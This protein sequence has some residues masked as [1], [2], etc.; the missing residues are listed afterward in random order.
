MYRT[1]MDDLCIWK[2]KNNRKPLILQGARQ[3]GKTWIMQEFGR[4]YF[5]NVAY[6][7]MDN[8]SRM[9][10]C[11]AKD[12]NVDR[13]IEELSVES[14]EQIIP[15]QTLIILDEVQEV[16]IALTAL[17]YFCED[18]P[19]QH[20]M[21][22][23]SLL[24]VAIHKGI[25]YPVGKVDILKMYPMTFDE[26]LRALQE[27]QLAEYS[28][29]LESEV[30][31]TFKDKYIDY[32]KKYYYIG[33]MPEAVLEYKNNKDYKEVRNIQKNIL[34]MYENDFGKHIDNKTELE[35]TRMVWNSI[36]M[37][38]SKENKKF[39]FRENK[40]GWKIERV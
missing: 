4:M 13:I 8:N 26:F 33:G 31:V 3:V 34:E 29:N 36:P 38:L 40:K 35:R 2:D 30:N 14:G 20:I 23:G 15:G 24:G 22:A 11:F 25:S 16:P 19:S 7:N 18:L 27:P 28:N 21:V 12:F 39:F 6:I 32:L 1:I 10:Q 37:Q 17:N 5:D 9:K